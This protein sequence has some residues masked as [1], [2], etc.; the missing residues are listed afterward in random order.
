[1]AEEPINKDSII[2]D[3]IFLGSKESARIFKEELIQLEKHI[4]ILAVEST[5]YFIVSIKTLADLE[6]RKEALQSVTNLEKLN[7]ETLKQKS[8]VEAALQKIEK[9]SI[10]NAQELEKLKQQEAKTSKESLK[11]YQE[12]EKLKQQ[13][14]KTS[15]ENI[16]TAQESEKLKRQ[17]IKT[18]KDA[19]TLKSKL[20]S[21][22]KKNKVAVENSTQALRQMQRELANLPAGSKEFNELAKKAGALKDKIGD[23]KD[24]IKAFS[25]ESKLTNSKTLFSQI[26][27]DLANM[28]FSDASDKAKILASVV[29]SMT[30]AEVAKG[31]K[32]FGSTLLNLGKAILLN[33]FTLILSAVVGLG[34]AL[35]NLKDRVKVIGDA[36]DFFGNII[37]SSIQLMKDFTDW[38]GITA[39]AAEEKAERIKKAAEVEQDAIKRRYDLEI[40]L[41]QIAGK[42]TLGL[43]RLQLLSRQKYLTKKLEQEKLTGDELTKILKEKADIEDAL[44]INREMQRQAAI[45]RLKDD[46]ADLSIKREEK[47]G[48]HVLKKADEL[49][50]DFITNQNNFYL[51]LDKIQSDNLKREIDRQQ[52]AIDFNQKRITDQQSADNEMLALADKWNEEIEKKHK[53]EFKKQID[54]ASQFASQALDGFKDGLKQKEEALLASDQKQIDSQKRMF[55]LQSKLAAEG[56]YNVLAET[57]AKID[58]LEEKKAR[59]QKRAINVQKNLAMAQI[60]TKSLTKSLGEDKPTIASIGE[61]LASSGIVANIFEK[62]ASGFYEGTEGLKQSDGIKIGSGKDN[63]LI[64][65]HEGEKIL[66]VEDS[67]KIPEGMTN[68]DIVKAAIAYN[69]P[70]LKNT[71]YPKVISETD[72]VSEFNRKQV[73]LMTKEIIN[74]KQ[75]V[76]DKP[77]PEINLGKLGE[78]AEKIKEGNTQTIIHH[79]KSGIKRPLQLHG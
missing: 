55:D 10:K 14:A 61:A 69:N 2:E 54:S 37:S 25:S 76:I 77:V 9:E 57:E 63:I 39:F 48:K 62:L 65:A 53:E 36:F 17:E 49:N 74:L 24:A 45:K 47:K 60:I 1:M 44:T 43:E 67:A 20:E 66:G 22:E 51:A 73:E 12:L 30:F 59:D 15:K 40:K 64:R 46:E 58:M 4:K 56:K 31:V 5:K 33:P 70:E 34:V 75:A 29:R 38:T 13:D 72:S 16:K 21:Q 68:K 27:S 50:T 23:A 71:F 79:K 52:G 8:I 78:W 18:T 28:N 19:I 32:D 7:T 26:G 11:A 6:K 3:D 42:E 35:Y 41:A